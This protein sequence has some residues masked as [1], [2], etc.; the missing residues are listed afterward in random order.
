MLI[1]EALLGGCVLAAP[2]ILV[3]VMLRRASQ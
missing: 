3:A 1:L 2:F